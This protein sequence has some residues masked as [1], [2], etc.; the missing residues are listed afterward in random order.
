MI[1]SRGKRTMQTRYILERV[2]SGHSAYGQVSFFSQRYIEKARADL[3]EL[4]RHSQ[5]DAV[6]E[7]V[8]QSLRR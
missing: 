3:A 6:T 8:N 7:R 2:L 1:R 5:G 4:S